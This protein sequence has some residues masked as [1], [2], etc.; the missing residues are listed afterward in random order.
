M[1]LY[2]TNLFV[3]LHTKQ[4]LK[5]IEHANFMMLRREKEPPSYWYTWRIWKVGWNVFYL[6][7]TT[8]FSH[9]KLVGWSRSCQQSTWKRCFHFLCTWIK[10][11]LVAILCCCWLLLIQSFGVQVWMIYSLYSN[12][13]LSIRVRVLSRKCARYMQGQTRNPFW[14]RVR[15]LRFKTW[16]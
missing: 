16:L 11:P 15:G 12:I 8:S 1:H 9:M 2:P 5:K 6:Q 14:P 13:N 3:T 10:T 4:T 7:W